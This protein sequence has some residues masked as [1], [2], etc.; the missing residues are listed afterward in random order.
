[1]KRALAIFLSLSLW[2]CSS[3]K[4]TDEDLREKDRQA[5]L[6]HLD[7]HNVALYKLAKVAV[8]SSAAPDQL[9]PELQAVSADLKHLSDAILDYGK[10]APSERSA[11]DHLGLLRNYSKLRALINSTDEDL[12]PTLTDI[13]ALQQSD[14]TG[15]PYTLLSGE[16][17][18]RT[19]N[20]EH[21]IMSAF[22]LLLKGLGK[23]VALYECAKT[24]PDKLEDSELKSLLQFYRGFL[25]FEKQL[26]YLSEAEFTRNINWLDM[27]QD[28]ELPFV[29]ILFQWPGADDRSTHIAFHGMNHLVRGYDRLMM[30]RDVDEERALQD[31]DVFLADAKVLGLDNELIWS[32]EAYLS[33][34]R[35]DQEKA[36]AA[37]TKLRSSELLSADE[38]T[39][40]D[41]SIAYVRDREPGKALNGLYDKV[42]LGKIVSKYLLSVLAKVDWRKLMIEQDVPNAGA[43]FDALDGLH[44]FL[45][46]AEK[47][48]GSKGVDAAKEGV[49]NIW[50][51]AK[52][53]IN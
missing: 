21:T 47:Y 26:H 44:E 5:L 9:P 17:K 39:Q 41:A 11:W 43:M 45:L 46:N 20:S 35:E 19:Q 13:I 29:R 37:L 23:D 15:I 2:A 22:A 42:F 53:T 7:T 1:M 36:I 24:D 8:R 10:T 16:E 28:V 18:L 4:K 48:T 25:F 3:E 34:K 31:F 49:K 14:S 32:V 6:D 12:F 40:L 38:H 50:D 27:D 30:G 33:L 51:E 52:K